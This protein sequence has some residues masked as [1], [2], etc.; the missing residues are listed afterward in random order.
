LESIY[1]QPADKWWRLINP[2]WVNPGR[3][4]EKKGGGVAA[5]IDRLNKAAA[6]VEDIRTT[7]HPT[8]CYGSFCS[9]SERLSYGEVVFKV[10]DREVWDVRNSTLP[11]VESWKL[12]SDDARGTLK[13][14]AGA[15]VLTLTLQPPTAP[16]DET[17][18]A[19]RSAKQIAG[20]LFVHGE[21]K[22]KSYEHQNSYAD[23]DV[24]ASL[25][26]SVVQIA[27]TAKWQ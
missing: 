7:F 6:F 17:V 11:P 10:A 2:D 18:P 3:V 23:R 12:L 20:K 4:N 8:H 15:R 25:L 27:K 1:L 9:S 5:V 22:G 26:Y 24:L 13:V 14:Q 21:T 16:G 19:E